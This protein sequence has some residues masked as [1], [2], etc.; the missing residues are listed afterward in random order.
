MSAIVRRNREGVLLRYD[1]SALRAHHIERK[2][3]R[4]DRERIAVIEAEH[5]LI[6]QEIIFE[7]LDLS[8]IARTRLDDGLRAIYRGLHVRR[9]RLGMSLARTVP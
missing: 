9:R 3:Q 6:V 5:E 8:D 1:P 4:S 2:P 7:H